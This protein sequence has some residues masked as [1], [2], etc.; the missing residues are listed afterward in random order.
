MAN[1]GDRETFWQRMRRGYERF[2]YQRLRFEGEGNH[3]LTVQGSCAILE[4]TRECIVLETRD[5]DVRKVCVCG[6]DL[7]C[8][9]YYPDAVRIRGVIVSVT[10]CEN[11][12][13]TDAN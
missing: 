6:R 2:S 8:L 4:Y 5:P 3:L 1:K 12:G 13:K 9:S 11:G 10:F 7:L